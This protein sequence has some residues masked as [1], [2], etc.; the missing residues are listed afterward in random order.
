MLVQHSLSLLYQ[1]TQLCTAHSAAETFRHTSNYLFL[2]LLA[3][4]AQP[5]AS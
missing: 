2:K 4:C 5:S 3:A 1:Q